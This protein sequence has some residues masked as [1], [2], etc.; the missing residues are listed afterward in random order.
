MG[1][2]RV[3]AVADGC[4]DRP[5]DGL[6]IRPAE[7]T[8]VL[9]VR[10]GRARDVGAAVAGGRLLRQGA[11]Q[12]TWVDRF[13][14]ENGDAGL[15]LHLVHGTTHQ[16]ANRLLLTAGLSCR[17][18]RGYR[19][20]E[21]LFGAYGRPG[22]GIEATMP[23]S[24]DRDATPPG[25]PWRPLPGSVFPHRPG[26]GPASDLAPVLSL[27][28]HAEARYLAEV[29]RIYQRSAVNEPVAF[30][31]RL[32]A[33]L[34]RY[35]L[36]ENFISGPRLARLLELRM[37]IEEARR[38]LEQRWLSARVGATAFLA[39][40]NDLTLGLQERLAWLL[41]PEEYHCLLE[42]PPWDRVLLGDLRQLM[43]PREPYPLPRSA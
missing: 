18:A 35:R 29:R 42:Q 30:P 13:G 21:I 19:V 6:A 41:S 39:G 17:G 11:G 22:C 14:G 26:R 28:D 33:A 40:F 4:R 36:G 37:E 34:L 1:V 16:I 7:H 15:P 12:W 8:Y 31:L 23:G 24:R 9:A 32:F 20:S 38:R 5:V 25:V 27:A 3:Y 43:G 2:L 10:D